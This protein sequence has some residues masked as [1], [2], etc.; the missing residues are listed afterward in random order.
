MHVKCLLQCLV[1]SRHSSKNS[2]D[3]EG[4]GEGGGKEEGEGERGRKKKEEKEEEGSRRGR[5]KEGKTGC[6]SDLHPHFYSTVDK[7]H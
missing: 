4:E 5:K 6:M 2:D 3:D 7:S 1:H